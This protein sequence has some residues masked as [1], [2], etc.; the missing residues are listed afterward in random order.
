MPGEGVIKG[1]QPVEYADETSFATELTDTDF[2]WFGIVDSWSVD[3][4]VESE[5]IT[6]LPEAEASNKLE[7]RV[8]VKLREMWEADLTY[9]PQTSDFSFFKYVTGDSTGLSDTLD[10]IQIGE[11]NEDAGPDY[12]R[13]LGG[14]G[15]ELTMSVEEDSV[16]EID[17]SWVFADETGWSSTDYTGTGSHASEDDTRPLTYDDLANVKY[18]GSE[19]D[20]MVESLELSVS[21]EIAQVRDPNNSRGTQ[22]AALVP[23]D[24]EITVD[25]DITYDAFGILDDVRSYTDA[26]LTFD[27]DGTS[28][29]VE[30]VSFPEAPYE[31]TADD[32]VSDSI[33]S[34]PCDGL[35]WTP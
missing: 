21:N 27:L 23:V 1:A 9:H 14:V 26:N 20:G 16:V 34:D 13:F 33:S 25:I 8:N 24:R 18:N 5:S 29:T 28:F 15:E 3:Q 22:I 30:G 17:T 10:S 32:L 7:K 4:G 2:N 35:S 11:V 6:Y 31:F 12:R 19:L